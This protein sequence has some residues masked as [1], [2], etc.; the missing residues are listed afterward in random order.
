MTRYQNLGGNSNVWGY[1]TG[2][3]WIAVQ[4]NDGATYTYTDVSAG[5]G[6]IS[7]MKA[8]AARGYGLNGFINTHVRKMYASRR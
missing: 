6:N 8:L 3:D 2:A 7:Q 5:V 4:F 1:D